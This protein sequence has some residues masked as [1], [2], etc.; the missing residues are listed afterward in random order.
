MWTVWWF[1]AVSFSLAFSVNSNEDSQCVLTGTFLHSLF[2]GPQTLTGNTY[3]CFRRLP[4]CS[5][6]AIAIPTPS[7]DVKAKGR[8]VGWRGGGWARGERKMTD[9]HGESEDMCVDN[10]R[11]SVIRWCLYKS[12]VLGQRLLRYSNERDQDRLGSCFA[13]ARLDS[14]PD[15][16]GLGDSRQLNWWVG[17]TPLY[18]G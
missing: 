4:A 1:M 13:P 7:P 9:W 14:Y 8:G 18:G 3:G 11:S 10:R 17:W 16:D 5:C 12:A 15:V 6:F 2:F